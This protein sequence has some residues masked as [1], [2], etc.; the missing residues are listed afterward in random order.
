MVNVLSLIESV[1][2]KNLCSYLQRIDDFFG[3]DF[4]RFD[5]LFPTVDS[6]GF[7]R[8]NNARQLSFMFHVGF[9]EF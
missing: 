4:G 3:S 5:Y 1:I 7:F 9:K 2:H 6:C 8:V